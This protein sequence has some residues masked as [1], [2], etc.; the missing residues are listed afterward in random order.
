MSV[1]RFHICW[2][3]GVLVGLA[4]GAVAQTMALWPGEV[5][6]FLPDP[7]M[8]ATAAFF[9]AATAGT[10]CSGFF[11]RAGLFGWVIALCA[12]PLV[13]LFGAALAAL[14]FVYSGRKVLWPAHEM[15]LEA[16]ASGVLGVGVS[17]ASSLPVGALWVLAALLVHKAMR[18][19][20]FT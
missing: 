2:H 17:I 16:L 6:R 11:G 20:R 3:G 15:A 8:L 18:A 7:L 14:P 19:E 10:L 4:G 13:T 5:A 9:G 12:W 1:T